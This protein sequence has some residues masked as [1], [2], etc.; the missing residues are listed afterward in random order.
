VYLEVAEHLPESRARGLIADLNGLAPCVLFSAAVPGPT[1]TGHINAQ[2]L[3]YWIELFAVRGYQGVDAIR[4]AIWGNPDVEWFYQQDIVIFR[5]SWPSDIVEGLP[6]A[7]EH[8]SSG[9]LR[10]GEKSK[11]YVGDD[12]RPAGSP[13]AVD[14]LSDE[15]Q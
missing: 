12:A 7:A 2:Y 14:G 5:K 8:D 3:P 6:K 13:S 11:A 9:T 15:A 10:S 1:G 4:P